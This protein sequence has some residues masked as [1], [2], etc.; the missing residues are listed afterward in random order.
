M[1]RNDY[2]GE[3]ICGVSAAARRDR[4]H[5]RRCAWRPKGFQKVEF[6]KGNADHAIGEPPPAV[7]VTCYAPLIRLGALGACL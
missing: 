6:S 3:I 2:K 4:V 1:K 7:V 5:R